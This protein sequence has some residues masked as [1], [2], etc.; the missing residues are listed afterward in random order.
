MPRLPCSE[1]TGFSVALSLH[2]IDKFLRY[3]LV[4]CFTLLVYKLNEFDINGIKVNRSRVGV[5]L[6]VLCCV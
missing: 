4:T 3:C 6:L 5:I 2:Y 1:L